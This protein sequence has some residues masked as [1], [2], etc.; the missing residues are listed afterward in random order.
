MKNHINQS[1]SC[2]KLFICC[3]TAPILKVDYLESFYLKKK[4]NSFR[5]SLYLPLKSFA[6]S[7]ISDI[8]VFIFDLLVVLY[9]FQKVDLVIVTVLVKI[10]I[11]L[12]LDI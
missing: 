2:G 3:S 4:V 11:Y 12:F 10:F 9:S 5:K 8:L 7:A 6:L 1:R